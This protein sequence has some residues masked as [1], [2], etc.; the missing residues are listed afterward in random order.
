MG[1]LSVALSNLVL[2]GLWRLLHLL[3]AAYSFLL[4]FLWRLNLFDRLLRCYHSSRALDIA[5][6]DLRNLSRLPVH[7]GFVFSDDPRRF[8]LLNVAELIAWCAA[9]GISCVS[10]Y[11][12]HGFWRTSRH[13]L[14][15][16]VE[17]K[18]H[19]CKSTSEI[20]LRVDVQSSNDLLQIPL[21]T[22][23]NN[24]KPWRIDGTLIYFLSEADG[25]ATLVEGTRRIC[26]AVKDRRLPT[27]VI[28]Q[29]LF[30]SHIREMQ[31]FPDPDLIMKIGKVDS[32]SGY[33]PWQVR[34]SEILY[35]P[36][37]REVSFCDF[38]DALFRFTRVEQRL[39]R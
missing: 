14:Q 25:K 12:K 13:E 39:G 3:I 6:S 18:L 2:I 1:S 37:P 34:L 9:V 21:L 36:N 19:S 29:N 32:L 27:S 23:Q 26:S 33:P 5:R 10:I 11:D 28:D 31:D 7:L 8:A 22:A 15:R 35:M 30:D 24:A 16:V 20:L 17:K 4:S 38:R